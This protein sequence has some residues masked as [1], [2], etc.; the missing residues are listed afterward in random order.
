MV[1]NKQR[2]TKYVAFGYYCSSSSYRLV[3]LPASC[4]PPP[5]KPLQMSVLNSRASKTRNTCVLMCTLD[6]L[7]PPSLR[8]GGSY[9]CQRQGWHHSSILWLREGCGCIITRSRRGA[10][11]P[12]LQSNS[13]HSSLH[14]AARARRST[15]SGGLLHRPRHR[16]GRSK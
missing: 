5:L 1:F 7:S 3:P 10:D 2:C 6:A 11:P 12:L 16:R 15:L 4:L 14:M 9:E 8:K 13:D